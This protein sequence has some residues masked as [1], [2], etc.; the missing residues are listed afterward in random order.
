MKVPLLDLKPQYGQ[1][2][3]K[4]VPEILA[5]MES[6]MFILG[7]KVEKM[8]KELADY[9]GAKHALGVSSGT[10]AILIALMALDLKPGDE[11]ITTPYTFFATAGCIHRA[12]AKAVFVDIEPDTFN[13]DP[14]KIE[15]AISKKTR[16]IMP[17]HL[18]GQCADMDAINAVAK[19]HNLPVIEDCAQAIGSKNKGRQAGNMSLAGC[20]SF[21][22]SK[23]LGCFGD[24][25]L[26]T[27]N[28]SAYFDRIKRLRMHGQSGTYIHTEVGINGRLDALQAAVISAKLPLL[29]GWSDGRRRNAARYAELFKKIPQVKP[30]VARAENEHIYNQYVIRVP[31]RDDLK[32]HLTKHEIGCAVYYPL[33]LHEQECFKYLGYKKGDFPVSEE[34]AQCTLALPVFPELVPEQIDFVGKTIAEFYK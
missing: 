17:V 20:F 10:D 23:N 14:K 32:A 16:A 24:G 8:E 3:D 9:I 6:Q 19:A 12:G 33:S 21:F 30:P 31:K 4:L 18:F 15:K 5:I 29:A 7:P 22:P 27:T 26:I 25:G 2:K 34:A 1:F 11:I 28:D 13:I